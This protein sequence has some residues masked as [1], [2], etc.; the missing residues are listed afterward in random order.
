VPWLLLGLGPRSASA[1]LLGSALSSAWGLGSGGLLPSAL[2]WGG[3]CWAPGLS[4]VSA[5]AMLAL[6]PPLM[7]GG[8]R[9]L[10]W[11]LL[12]GPLGLCWAVLG[13]TLLVAL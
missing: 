12:G 6:L 11:L 4:L 8:W 7:A 13:L 3:Y 2:G 9:L 1:E 10:R 5:V